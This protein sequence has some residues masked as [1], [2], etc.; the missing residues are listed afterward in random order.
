MSIQLEAPQ[1]VLHQATVSLRQLYDRYTIIVSIIIRE[2][3]TEIHTHLQKFEDQRPKMEL[4]IIR[5]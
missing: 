5:N 4:E 3:A 1:P 2:E